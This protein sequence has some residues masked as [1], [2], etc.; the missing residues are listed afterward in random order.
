[1]TSTGG[2]DT[3]R[4]ARALLQYRNTPLPGLGTSPAQLLYGRKLRDH[5]PTLPDVLRIRKEW[6]TSAEDRERA[7]AKRHLAY[8][9]LNVTI[10]TLEHFQC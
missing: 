4:F 8:L 3:D 7:L 6:V 10:Q 2:L 5:I 9:T 1:M